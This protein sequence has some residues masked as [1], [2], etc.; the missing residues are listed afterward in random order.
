MSNHRRAI[1]EV[2]EEKYKYILFYSILCGL[3][4]LEDIYAGSY[5]PAEKCE[6]NK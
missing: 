6:S 4:E 1:V 5:S 2:V 3:E